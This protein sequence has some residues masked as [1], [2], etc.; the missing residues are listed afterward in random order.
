VGGPYY[1]PF[2]AKKTIATEGTEEQGYFSQSLPSTM[3]WIPSRKWRTLRLMSR[4][5]ADSTPAQVGEQ[6]CLVD[7]VE[8]ADGLHFHRDSVFYYEIVAVSD[9]QLLTFINN[10]QSYLGCYCETLPSFLVGEQGRLGRRSQ[11]NLGRG[12]NG[13]SWRHSPRHR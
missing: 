5:T 10:G 6:L 1:P 4:P 9:F 8:R 7:R 11:V 13:L 12:R 2:F 3:R